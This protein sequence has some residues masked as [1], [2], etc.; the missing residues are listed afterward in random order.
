MNMSATSTYLGSGEAALA[1]DSTVALPARYEDVGPIASGAF[2]EVRRVR[3]HLFRRMVAIKLLRREYADH[4]RVRA[5]FLNEAEITAGLQHPAVVAVYDRG[6]L[7]DGRLW[8]TMQEV[9][10]RTFQVALA[11]L[12]AAKSPEGFR[13][14]PSGWTFQH[15][16]AAF[17][18]V[19]EA[20]GY[21][22]R[23]GI[24][25]RDLKPENL[26]MG[27]LGEVLVMDWGLA[28][29]VADDRGPGGG[30][31]GLHG[32]AADPGLTCEGDVLGTPAYMPPEQAAGQQRLHSPQ[33]DVYALGA[34]LYHLLSGQPPYRTSG[35]LPFRQILA[36]PPLPVAEA[37]R[38]G[39]QPPAELVAICSRAMAREIA[40]RY[41]DA[42]AVAEEVRSW[43]DRTFR[44]EQALRVV[45]RAQA[46]LPDVAASREQAARAKAEADALLAA[47]RP[48]DPL[49]RKQR[50]WARQ[51][52]AEAL[53]AEA[54]VREA[55]WLTRMHGALCI[56]P[57]LPDAHAALAGYYEARL[58]EAE[59][60]H[61]RADALRLEA[62][63]RAHDRGKH[64]ALLSAAGELSLV[65]EPPGA[66]VV[67]ERYV[68][69]GRRL[70][71]E[72]VG[73]LGL[74]PL[75]SV[76][77]PRG[78][79][80]LRLRAPGRAEVLYPALIERD[81]H[82]D[83][84]APGEREPR[85]IWLP[86]EG[87]LGADDVY[88]P[89]GYCWTGGDPK[90]PYSL[91]A[92]RIW[93]DAFVIR[94]FPVTNREYLEFLN[95]LVAAG[96]EREALSACPRER[97]GVAGGSG[98]RFA[99]GRDRGGRFVLTP[100]DLG[101]THLPDAPVT[102]IGWRAASAYA[103]WLAAREGKPWRLPSELER[104][105]AARGAD[106]R[107]YPFGNHLDVQFV[108]TRDGDD[109]LPSI[110]S[111]HE[112]PLDESPYGVRGLGGNSRDW[113]RDRWT[114]E[115]PRLDGGRL[116]ANVDELGARRAVR[117]GAWLGALDRSRS[118]ARAGVPGGQ[119]RRTTGVRVVR[120]CPP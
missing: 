89:A 21:A 19:A 28:R 55:E 107:I 112:I 101:R 59:R 41:P 109:G 94:R 76:K 91:P 102:L 75:R 88:V 52:E 92:R 31:A 49:D 96:R 97:A 25:H 120:A 95:D 6:E 7:A 36:G 62:L 32:R 50:G 16:V 33:S 69:R 56:D 26:M 47:A 27:E 70:I 60:A 83:G 45:R 53:S 111:V 4:P 82:W 90:A 8:F 99:F 24:V 40:A 1:C 103:R 66:T 116:A 72:T 86:K 37:A 54:A 42:S 84:V 64:A 12:H 35:L 73:E 11:E 77:L 71:P 117:G 3:D 63:L 22:H 106:G 48:R 114:R 93:F 44:R 23:Q 78:S 68:E 67:L 10:G 87:E 14:G 38:G 29:R 5:R 2:G 74:T 17:A 39:P 110:A 13:P 30:A 80:R 43:L 9:R 58:A 100:N 65:T 98:R 118:A 61:R 20:V 79:Y 57:E 15:A 108:R 85:P 119:R 105:R 51:D 46:L 34:V 18:R 115:G 81:G 113:C 104:E